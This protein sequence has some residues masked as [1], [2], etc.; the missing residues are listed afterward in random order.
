MKIRVKYVVEDTDR[1]GNVRLYL[2]KDGRKLRLRGPLGCPDFWT[3][4]HAALANPAPELKAKPGA[5][6]HVN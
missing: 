4:Y 1:H 3:D 5:L 6:S 2:R